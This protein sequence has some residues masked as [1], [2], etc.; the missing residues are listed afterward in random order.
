MSNG[1]P[2]SITSVGLISTC[3]CSTTSASEYDIWNTWRANKWDQ[4]SAS[5]TVEY[6]G[7]QTTVTPVLCDSV[8]LGCGD[9]SG[10]TYCGSRSLVILDAQTNTTPT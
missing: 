1:V 6:G 8:S 2:I 10:L 9:G 7:A 4:T 5:V 3:D